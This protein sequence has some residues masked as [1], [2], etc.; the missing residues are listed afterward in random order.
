MTQKLKAH[1]SPP[2]ETGTWPLDLRMLLHS[3]P[4]HTLLSSLFFSFKAPIDFEIKLAVPPPMNLKL[5]SPFP[6]SPSPLPAFTS[7][8]VSVISHTFALKDFPIRM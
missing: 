6:G 5:A 1:F 8:Q 4:L 7:A 3:G 2:I